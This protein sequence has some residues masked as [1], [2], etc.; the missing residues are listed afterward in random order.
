MTSIFITYLQNCTTPSL[1]KLDGVLP[2]IQIG[3]DYLDQELT[4]I[5][6]R[7]CNVT[8][9]TVQ[10]DIIEQKRRIWERRA[11]RLIGTLPLSEILQINKMVG[12]LG[13]WYL[14]ID[15]D[16]PAGRAA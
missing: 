9:K 13:E 6:Q 10:L 7:L 4:D 1:F 12:T 8:S 16:I 11:T 14:A 5:F 2:F 3:S 15:A